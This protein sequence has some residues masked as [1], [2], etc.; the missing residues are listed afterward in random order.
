M[1]FPSLRWL[2]AKTPQQVRYDFILAN[3]QRKVSLS[4]YE[5]WHYVS[6]SYVFAS[7]L[8]DTRLMNRS[9]CHETLT[10]LEP[11]HGWYPA[12]KL[13]QVIHTQQCL[14]QLHNHAT[15]ESLSR[16]DQKPWLTSQNVLLENLGLQSQSTWGTHWSSNPQLCQS[17]ISS[18]SP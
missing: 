4:Q 17:T 8:K 3:L 14:F 11:F 18:F 6:N 5:N 13:P 16:S 2:F 10:L 1:N 7:M 9:S 15:I 12:F